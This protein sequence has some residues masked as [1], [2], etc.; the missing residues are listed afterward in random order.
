[1]KTALKDKKILKAPKTLLYSLLR[2]V[3]WVAFHVVFPLKVIN[4]DGLQ[5]LKA[6]YILIANH[7]NALDPGVLGWL[8]PHELWCLGKKELVQK[9]FF[10][11]L[12]E[13][14]LH[15]IPVSR[16]NFDLQAM[17]SCIKTLKEGKVLCIFP[18]GTR[19]LEHLMEKVEK[20]VVLLALRQKMDLVPVYIDGK[21]KPFRMNMAVIGEPIRTTEYF[22]DGY[23]EQNADRLVEIVRER[24]YKLRDMLPHRKNQSDNREASGR[25]EK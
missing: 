20:G 25:G 7:K 18:E 4:K 2:P 9:P 14:Q 21:L 6:P 5:H 8:C 24:F 23:T 19:H 1:M 3:G 13:K 12:L 17:R 11:W 16:H 15:M 22:E 10:S